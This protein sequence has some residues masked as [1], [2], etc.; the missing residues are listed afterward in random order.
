MNT[1]SGDKLV[2]LTT[3]EII[4][5]QTCSRNLPKNRDS[6]AQY[7]TLIPTKPCILR[8]T[9]GEPPYDIAIPS[10]YMIAK[11]M[12]EHLFEKLDQSKI[13]R[14]GK[15]R[16]KNSWTNRLIRQPNS[17]PYFGVPW[18]YLQYQDG[19][20]SWTLVRSLAWRVQKWHHDVRWCAWGHGN[21]S[22]TLGYSLNEKD[23]KKLQE[24]V[25]KLYTL[26]PNIKAL[27]ADEMK[28][29]M[30]Q[31]NAAIRVTFSGEASQMLEANKDLRYMS[32]QLKPATFGLITLSFQ[33]TVKK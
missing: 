25:D 12:D 24:A 32:S 4:L 29:Y 18:D 19:Q 7:D 31:N 17:V 9:Q 28:G 16:S 1:K 6:R 23:P 2:Y 30:I 10:E 21:W 8:S 15:Y 33:K 14:D 13:K 5:I 22:H 3:G 11:M 27:V 20:S 26:T